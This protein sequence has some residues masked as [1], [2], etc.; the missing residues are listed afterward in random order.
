[1]PIAA[2]S[3]AIA[4]LVPTVIW[5]TTETMNT[6]EQYGSAWA[7]T[8]VANEQSALLYHVQMRQA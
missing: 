1:M 3:T 5:P 4:G 7:D 6:H 2:S 8:H